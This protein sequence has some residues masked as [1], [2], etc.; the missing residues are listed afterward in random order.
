VSRVTISDLAAHQLGDVSRLCEQELALDRCASSIPRIV[1]RQPYVGLVAVQDSATVGACIGSV[2]EAGDGSGEGFIDLLVVDR[3]QQRQGI[4]RQLAAE[5]ERQLA[6]RGCQRIDLAAGSPNHAWPGVDVHYTAAVCFA[7]DSGYQ[8]QGCEVNM[9]VDLSGA[10]LDTRA[11]ENRLASEGIEVRRAD[12]DDDGPLQE[13]LGLIRQA[14]WIAE[15]T[16][17]LRGS[18]AGLHIAV[19]RGRYVGFCCYGVN[20]AHE[21]GPIGTDPEMRSL[22]I[23]SVLLKRCLAEQRDRGI[24][25]AELVWVGPLSYFF[26]AVHATIGRVFWQYS[27]DLSGA[28]RTPDWRDRIGLI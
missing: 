1:T 25:A 14:D 22:G 21:V 2:A 16:Q 26:R 17:A 8:R 18:E 15:I 3:A 10:P 24:T 5:M 27:K 9:D 7:E 20:R 19:Q 11:A 6:A 13:L 28:S 4:G 12:A 23:G